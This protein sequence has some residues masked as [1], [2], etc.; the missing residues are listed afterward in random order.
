MAMISHR[1]LSQG[2]VYDAKK[3]T[4]NHLIANYIIL[5]MGGVFTCV[6]YNYLKQERCLA[7][8]YSVCDFFGAAT[9]RLL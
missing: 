3:I 4:F 7:A 6:F 2:E 8:K 1:Q 9:R 5:C